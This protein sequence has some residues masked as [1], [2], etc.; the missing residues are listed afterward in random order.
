MKLGYLVVSNPNGGAGVR[1]VKAVGR[2]VIEEKG[3]TG[4]YDYVLNPD[5]RQC[6][7]SDEGRRPPDAVM[8]DPTC[9]SACSRRSRSN[10][11]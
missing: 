9:P 5:A 3:F 8:P 1:P 4:N 7:S 6:A 11:G 10:W 2:T